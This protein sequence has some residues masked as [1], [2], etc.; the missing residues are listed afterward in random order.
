VQFCTWSNAY[1]AKLEDTPAIPHCIRLFSF[2]WVGPCVAES[3]N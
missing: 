3:L 2:P 1:Q